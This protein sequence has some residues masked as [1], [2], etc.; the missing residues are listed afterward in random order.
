MPSDD[1]AGSRSEVDGIEL[2]SISRWPT[3]VG[4]NRDRFA[5]PIQGL[6]LGAAIGGDGKSALDHQ[7][8]LNSLTAV[9][10]LGN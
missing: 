9:L 7:V 10:R 6:A 1:R 2:A 3:P 4:V 8:G 5:A